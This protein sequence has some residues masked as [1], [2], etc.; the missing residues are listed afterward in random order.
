[1]TAVETRS[2]GRDSL[3]MMALVRIEGIEG[4]HRVKVR[5]LSAGGMMAE[6]DVRVDR[7]RRLTIELR[8]I[9]RVQGSIAWIHG[10]RFGIAFAEEI[11]PRRAR[12]MVTVADDLETPR[13]VRPSSLL[14]PEPPVD[15]AR[16]RKI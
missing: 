11:D 4:E 15:P 1:M 16:L 9:G 14:P 5:N 3:F 12:Q 13:F 8:N 7:D 2:L 6:G 10:N